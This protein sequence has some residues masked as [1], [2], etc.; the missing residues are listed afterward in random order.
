LPQDP[1][2][3]SRLRASFP[4]LASTDLEA[5]PEDTCAVWVQ[6]G[7]LLACL[8]PATPGEDGQD[9]FGRPLPA[10]S[11]DSPEPVAGPGVRLRA[12]Q[13]TYEATASGYAYVHQATLGVRAPLA[14]SADGLACTFA[15]VPAQGASLPD[16]ED[17][18]AWLEEKGICRGIDGQACQALARAFREN[19]PSPCLFT[20]AQGLAPEHGRDAR[21]VFEIDCQRKPGRIDQDGR[22]DFKETA[23]GLNVPCG[24][25]LARLRPATQGR[26]GF[27]VRGE[28]LP[29][30]SGQEAVLKAGANVEVIEAEEEWVYK[31]AVDGRVSHHRDTLQV[32]ETLHLAADVDYSTGNIDF[33]GD[34]LVSGSVLAGFAVRAGGSIAVRGQVESGARLEAMG[35]IVVGG[36]A[37]GEQTCLKA[38]GNIAIYFAQ[39]ATLLAGGDLEVGSYLFNAVVRCQGRALVHQ[40]RS[41]R[42]GTIAGG[43][44]LAARGIQARFAGSPNGTATELVVGVDPAIEAALH[45]CQQELAECEKEQ[46]HLCR[47]LGL[48]KVTLP[49]L[50]RLLAHAAPG[51][52]DQIA[53]HVRRWQQLERQIPAL[54]QQLGDLRRS[55]AQPAP[56]AVLAI[57]ETIYPGV[58]LRLGERVAQVSLELREA[59]LTPS[60]FSPALLQ[61]AA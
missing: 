49:R 43:S 46:E 60:T 42:S 48:E 3:N 52:R 26:A 2:L 35:D 57:A 32:H 44:V 1:H 13:V 4:A 30:F 25:L 24:A 12:D 36:G 28:G 53:D 23:F 40:G 19:H 38:Q 17:I 59:C 51:R 56:D 41:R 8:H 58:C 20:L 15:Y 11:E 61:A 27:T 7:Q 10:L 50:R 21:L 54:Q 16:E 37:V 14:L 6:P 45:G 47:L 33:S 22:I 34:V 18:P 5:L 31:A 29:A 55:L 39:D 9:V